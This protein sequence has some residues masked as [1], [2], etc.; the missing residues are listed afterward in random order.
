MPEHIKGRVK[1]MECLF[2]RA[3]RSMGFVLI[4]DGSKEPQDIKWLDKPTFFT[5]VYRLKLDDQ[6]VNTWIRFT[7]D[8]RTGWADFTIS[9]KDLAVL[10]DVMTHKEAGDIAETTELGRETENV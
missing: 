4:R 7:Y 9:Y 10:D 1:P 2:E 3:I 8:N 6:W 5:R